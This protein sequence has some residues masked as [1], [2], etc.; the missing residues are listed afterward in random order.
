MEA[1]EEAEEAGTRAVA[2][3]STEE[4]V[5]A[6]EAA[7]ITRAAASSSSRA[8]ATAEAATIRDSTREAVGATAEGEDEATG[9]AEVRCTGRYWAAW[10]AAAAVLPPNP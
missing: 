2:G 4:A 5:E 8:A 1:S 10:P 9:E 6:E 7:A 3:T